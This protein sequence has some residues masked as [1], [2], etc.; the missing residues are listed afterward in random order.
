MPRVKKKRSIKECLIHISCTFNNT[1]I[2]ISDLNGNVVA[3]AS[4]GR[5][6]R[7]SKK[8]T[9]FAAQVAVELVVRQFL[10]NN[11]LPVG[12]FPSAHIRVRGPGPGRESGIRAVQTAGV[13][14]V[15]ICDVTPL[16]HNG[17]RARKKR[18]A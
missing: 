15:S 7:G 6:F 8:S 13:N 3:Q 14:I 4:A 16:A 18:R 2:S 12:V 10:E 11:N 17:C 5:K 9:A 1:L